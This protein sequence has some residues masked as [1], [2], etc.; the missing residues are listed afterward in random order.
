MELDNRGLPP[1]QGLRPGLEMAPAELK[2]M[3][4]RGEAWLLDCREIAEWEL[5]R[6][7]GSTLI[8]LGE[9][10]ERLDEIEER[11]DEIESPGRIVV[12]CHHGVRSLR[13]ALMLRAHG[14]E[15]WSLAGGIDLWSRAIDPGV[16]RYDSRP[17]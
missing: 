2:V 1:G 10:E 7:E 14:I 4:E 17:R 5:A 6:I 15:A 16:P 9:I 3:L 11:L 12:V 13:A 8:P